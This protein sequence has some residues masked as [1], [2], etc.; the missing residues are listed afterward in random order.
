[1]KVIFDG[2]TS[3]EFTE[4]DGYQNAVLT[5]VVSTGKL[6]W[7]SLVVEKFTGLL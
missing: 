5:L 4:V 1:M 6:C 3:S 2:E 7:L